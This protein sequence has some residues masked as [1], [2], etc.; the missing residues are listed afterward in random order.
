MR[1][2]NLE[3]IKGQVIPPPALTNWLAENLGSTLNENTN[4]NLSIEIGCGVGMHPLRYALANLDKKILA[5][6]R[7][8]EK[9]KKFLQRY[10]NHGSP[11]NLFPVQAEAG[12]LLPQ[13]IHAPIVSEYII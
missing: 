2:L 11:E 8:T 3:K 5:I 9:F 7:T 12:L 6:E 10:K 4:S 13:I 1:T